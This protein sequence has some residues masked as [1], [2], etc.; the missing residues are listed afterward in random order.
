[1]K[2]HSLALAVRK[3]QA[4][5]GRQKIQNSLSCAKWQRGDGRGCCKGCLGDDTQLLTRAMPWGSGHT[6]AVSL[7]TAPSLGDPRLWATLSSRARLGFTVFGIWT[8]LGSAMIRLEDSVRVPRKGKAFV[9][10][11]GHRAVPGAPISLGHLGNCVLSTFVCLFPRWP[12][13]WSYCRARRPCRDLQSCTRRSLPSS[14]RSSL[15]FM[16]SDFATVMPSGY[17]FFPSSL[18]P[19]LSP[20]FDPCLFISSLW[21]WYDQKSTGKELN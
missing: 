15:S 16:P 10:V 1:M 18:A 8:H 7:I 14:Q 9:L 13:A 6:R 5:W 20:D 2:E 17:L 3:L 4:W 12:S 11:S 21:P 19:H